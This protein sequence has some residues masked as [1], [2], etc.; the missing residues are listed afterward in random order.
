MDLQ[1]LDHFMTSQVE[2]SL[3]TNVTKKKIQKTFEG[4]HRVQ[5]LM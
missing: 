1:Q 4:H 3:I 2:A 5:F